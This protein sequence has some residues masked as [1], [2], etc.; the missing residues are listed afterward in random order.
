VATRVRSRKRSRWSQQGFTL[1][2][3][4]IIVIVVGVLATIALP[5]LTSMMDGAKVN[6]AIS[7][8]RSTLQEGQRQAI[9]N[10]EPCR[11]SVSLSDGNGNRNGN[12]GNGNAYGNGNGNSG[13]TNG[14]KTG[15]DDNQ[16]QGSSPSPDEGSSP[17]SNPLTV[18]KQCP[19]SSEP[20]IDQNVGLES[21]MKT[22]GSSKDVA[23]AFGVF[24]SAE[25]GVVGGSPTQD[26]SG[27]IVAFI[28]EKTVKKKCIAISSTLGLTR[29]GDYSGGVTPE[30]ITQE[31][32]CTALDWTKQ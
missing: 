12:S 2:E 28:P 19:A 20:D 14:N 23:I 7:G 1:V 25:F 18:T 9:R 16:G 29:V 4:L 24:G 22:S 5:S 10:N 32:V 17:S 26:S 6:Q 8:V 27:K 30:Q 3:T 31:G 11:V 15:H 13:N 21:N